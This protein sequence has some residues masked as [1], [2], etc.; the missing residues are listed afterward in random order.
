MNTNNPETVDVYFTDSG[1]NVPFWPTRNCDLPNGSLSFSLAPWQSN[2]LQNPNGNVT[3]NHD[4]TFTFQRCIPQPNNPQLCQGNW[5]FKQS[6]ILCPFTPDCR[7][8]STFVPDVTQQTQGSCKCATYTSKFDGMTKE[9]L[10]VHCEY[11]DNIT[12]FGNGF[13]NA[14]GTCTCKPGFTTPSCS[15]DMITSSKH[16]YMITSGN[17][18]GIQ[19]ENKTMVISFFTGDYAKV[20]IDG[21][22]ISGSITLGGDYTIFSMMLT[23]GAQKCTYLNSRVTT[24]FCPQIFWIPYSCTEMAGP[25]L[26]IQMTKI[27]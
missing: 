15:C 19:L 14:D 23:D 13:V 9:Y 25:T 27:L 16:T 10:G 20:N 1:F 18:H 12:C 11:G 5:Y 22:I 2:L 24:T 4:N 7:N 3:N 17:F 8:G 26:P 21:T 6:N